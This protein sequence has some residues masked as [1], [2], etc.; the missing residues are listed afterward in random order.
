MLEDLS[1]ARIAANIATAKRD[2]KMKPDVVSVA[3]KA[4]PLPNVKQQKAN[5]INVEVTTLLDHQYASTINMSKRLSPFKTKNMYPT[6]KP[7]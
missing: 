4:T 2:A 1:S 5:V 6:I 7:D 3:S